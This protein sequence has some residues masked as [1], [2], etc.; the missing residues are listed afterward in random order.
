[1]LQLEIDYNEREFVLGQIRKELRAIEK[2]TSSLRNKFKEEADT[3]K[4]DSKREWLEG[5][6][7]KLGGDVAKIT[8]LNGRP[9]GHRKN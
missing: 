8:N 9:S 2:K 5:F 3:S 7:T 6:Y 4:L 1:M